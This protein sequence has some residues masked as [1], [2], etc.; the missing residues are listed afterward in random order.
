MSLKTIEVRI[1]ADP[2]MN[3]SSVQTVTPGRSNDEVELAERSEA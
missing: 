3:A 1:L 2:L